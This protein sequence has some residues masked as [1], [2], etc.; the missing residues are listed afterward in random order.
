MV[1]VDIRRSSYPSPE[2][3]GRR[4]EDLAMATMLAG[5]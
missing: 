5:A 2:T 4:A 3:D 1:A